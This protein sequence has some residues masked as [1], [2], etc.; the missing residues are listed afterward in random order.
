MSSRLLSGQTKSN[1]S[2]R[3]LEAILSPNRRQLPVFS[4][5]SRSR[6]GLNF[7]LNFG[8]LLSVGSPLSVGSRR[9]GASPAKG[10]TD[11]NVLEALRRRCASSPAKNDQDSDEMVTT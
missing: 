9:Q 6:G 5:A 7:G 4:S 1:K 8:S 2:R 10:L 11:I 3:P